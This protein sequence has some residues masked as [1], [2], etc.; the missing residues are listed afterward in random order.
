MESKAPCLGCDAT[1]NR[2][3]KI[4]VTVETAVTSY[5]ILTDSAIYKPLG[6]LVYFEII[7]VALVT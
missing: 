7:P 1:E 4:I 3:C 2:Q 6:F 5:L